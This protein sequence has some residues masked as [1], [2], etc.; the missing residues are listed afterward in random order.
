VALDGQSC[1]VE[2][3]DTAGQEE[4][5]SLRDQWIRDAE[6]TMLLYSISSRSSFVRLKRFYN[7][8]KR[9]KND[10]QF[11]VLVVGNKIDRMDEREVSTAEGLALANK[12]GCRFMEFSAK[13]YTNVEESFFD[14]VRQVKKYRTQ[15]IRRRLSIDLDALGHQEVAPVQNRLYRRSLAGTESTFDLFKRL[16]IRQRIQGPNEESNTEAGRIRLTR[17]LIQ[18]AKDNHEREVRAYLTAGAYPDGQP[19]TEGA[20]IHVA[21]ASGN[22]NIVNLLL[23]KAAGVNARGPSGVTALQLA[24]LRGHSATVKLLLH[25]G[26]QIDQTSQP[27]GT[28]LLTAVSASRTEV[29]EILLKKGAN[30]NASG[31]PYGNA[32]QAAAYIGNVSIFEALHRAGANINARG[33]GGC[34]ALQAAAHAGNAG[35]VRS[36]L[37][38]GAH[39]D[40]GGSRYGH[41]LEAANACGHTETVSLLIEYGASLDTFRRSSRVLSE[42]SQVS[43]ESNYDSLDDWPLSPELPANLSPTSLRSRTCSD[44]QTLTPRVSPPHL[45]PFRPEINSFGFSA[46]HDPPDAN[47]E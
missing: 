25:K 22:V 44:I 21:S 47:A 33:E 2:V 27:H 34:T 3:L 39:V 18:A 11:P 16:V 9:V 26:A 23:K 14:L 17:Y 42:K 19:G 20:A 32:L 12:L 5:T 7:Q 13:T 30:V 31:A 1:M 43:S 28:A 41:A 38:R 45:A 36:L 40:T 10:D 29:V 15:P 4:Y 8:I 46:I 24:S 35:A 37:I 6:G